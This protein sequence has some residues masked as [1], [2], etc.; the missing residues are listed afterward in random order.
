MSVYFDGIGAG[1]GEGELKKNAQPA[2][3]QVLVFWE[4][5]RAYSLSRFPPFPWHSGSSFGGPVTQADDEQFM[6][7]CFWRKRQSKDHAA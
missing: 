5:S 7:V 6:W 4:V 3:S 1:K 2:T